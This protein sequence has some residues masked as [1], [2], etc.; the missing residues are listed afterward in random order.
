MNQLETWLLD[1]PV[2]CARMCLST[3]FGYGWRKCSKSQA[4]RMATARSGRPRCGRHG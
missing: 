3:S 4:R 1:N 2:W